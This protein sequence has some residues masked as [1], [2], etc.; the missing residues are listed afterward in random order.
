MVKAY[1]VG[2]PGAPTAGT[3]F[4]IDTWLTTAV[5]NFIIVNKT[6]EEEIGSS[7]DYTFSQPLGKIVRTNVWQSGDT[8][9]IDYNT[10]CV[11]INPCMP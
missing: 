10:F 4:F 7:P 1:V 11:N 9:K 3:N 8:F 6:I 5:V 2:D